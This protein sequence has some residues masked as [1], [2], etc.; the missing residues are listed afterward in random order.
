MN[1]QSIF[2]KD[3]GC[4]QTTRGTCDGASKVQPVRKGS[5]TAISEG[6]SMFQ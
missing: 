4:Q 2:P 5:D 3:M 6:H 1:Q